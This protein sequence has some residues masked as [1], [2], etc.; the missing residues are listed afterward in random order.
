MDKC[1]SRLMLCERRIDTLVVG[2]RTRSTTSRK[3]NNWRKKLAISANCYRYW[4]RKTRDSM[5]EGVFPKDERE[6]Y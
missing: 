2:T 5:F 3:V 1:L 6:G 4:F